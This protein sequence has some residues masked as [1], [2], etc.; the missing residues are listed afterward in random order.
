MKMKKTEKFRNGLRAAFSNRRRSIVSISLALTVFVAMNLAARP[1]F[2][3]QMLSSNI[4]LLPEAVYL[5][6][7]YNSANLVQMTSTAI[8]ALL[9]GPA[10]VLMYLQFQNFGSGVQDVVSIAPGMVASGCAGCGAGIVGLLGLTG[11]L[12]VLPFNGLLIT[13]AAIVMIVYFITKSGNPEICNL[14]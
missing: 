3:Q 13:P 12:A 1:I 4:L 5:V 6:F 7:I 2:S 8:Y 11:A 9:A 14:N 10:L